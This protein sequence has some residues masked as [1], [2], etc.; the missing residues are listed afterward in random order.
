MELMVLVVFQ[1][2]QDI[3][4]VE[5]AVIQDSVVYQEQ[6]EQMVHQVLV[7]IQA[8]AEVEFQALVVIAEAVYLAIVVIVER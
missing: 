5:L 2:I 6:M 7:V 3:V 1:V 4:E 8:I